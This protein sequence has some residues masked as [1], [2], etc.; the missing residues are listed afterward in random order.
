MEPTKS[1]PI[2][3]IIIFIVVIVLGVGAFFYFKNKDSKDS[4]KEV[5]SD[6]LIGF[7]MSSL[8]EERLFG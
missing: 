2:A 6:V 3:K 5:K 4:T 7:S 8:Q 1:S